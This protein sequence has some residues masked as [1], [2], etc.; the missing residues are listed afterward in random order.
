MV[1]GEVDRFP[2]E[3]TTKSRMVGFW[4]KIL[5]NKQVKLSYI[6]YRKLIETP[7]FN[8]KWVTKVK[9]ILDECGNSEIWISQMPTPNLSKMVAETLKNQFYQKWNSDLNKSSKG[10]NYGF[11]KESIKLEEYFLKLSLKFYTLLAKF[12]TANHRLPCEVLR[13]QYIE[14]SERKCH[15]GDKL[16]VG[17]EMQYLLICP[18]FSDERIKHIIGI[19]HDFSFINIRKV[20]RE[21]LKTEGEAE[22]FNIFRG[23]LRMLMNNKIM[24]DRYYCIN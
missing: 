9:Q 23:T 13:W 20:P 17:D 7:N 18:F 19:K 14:L 8:S 1:L 24:L 6:L 2:L 21:V 12:R 3:I 10:R 16:D 22:V 15:L 11:F 4:S 5:T